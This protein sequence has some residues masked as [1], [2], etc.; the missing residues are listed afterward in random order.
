MIIHAD[1][2]NDNTA[3][4]TNDNTQMRVQITKIIKIHIQN[5]KNTAIHLNLTIWK[6]QS[7]HLDEFLKSVILLNLPWKETK[8][9]LTLIWSKWKL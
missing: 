2:T 1:E 7:I 8:Q 3:D 6:A 5:Q 9:I 4:E